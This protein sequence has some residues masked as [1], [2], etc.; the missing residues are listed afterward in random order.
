MLII[1]FTRNLDREEGATIF[2]IIEEARE[3]ILEFLQGIVKAL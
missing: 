1:N 3:N 2:F